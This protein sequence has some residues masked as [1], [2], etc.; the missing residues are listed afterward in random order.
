MEQWTNVIAVA[1]Y[2]APHI[3]MQETSFFVGLA[4]LAGLPKQKCF[5]TMSTRTLITGTM[6]RWTKHHNSIV[7]WT[8]QSRLE[9]IMP[10]TFSVVVY[11][12]DGAYE[13]TVKNADM[14]TALQAVSYSLA[15]DDIDRIIIMDDTCFTVFACNRIGNTWTTK[16]PTTGYE[17]CSSD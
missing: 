15:N 12:L 7:P 4:R 17:D 3:T 9:N 11:H 13:H 16:E 5:V 10:D 6:S 2:N 14:M 8:R 1:S